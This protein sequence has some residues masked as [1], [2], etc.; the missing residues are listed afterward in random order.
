MEFKPYSA[1]KVC[2]FEA[3]THEYKNI[4]IDRILN[5]DVS[6]IDESSRKDLHSIVAAPFLPKGEFRMPQILANSIRHLTHLAIVLLVALVA[7][8]ASGAQSGRAFAA[9]DDVRAYVIFGSGSGTFASGTPVPVTASALPAGYKFSRWIVSGGTAADPAASSTTITPAANARSVVA[10]A[11]RE[12]VKQAAGG[13]Q[14]TVYSGTGS[15]LYDA[16]A[17][18]TIAANAAPAGYQ[19]SYWLDPYKLVV[20]AKA[21]NTTLTMPATRAYVYAIFARSTTAP[22]TV[23][24]TVTGGTPAGTTQ[25]TPGAKLTVKANAPAAGQVFDKWTGATTGLANAALAETILTVPTTPVALTATFKPAAAGTVAVTVTGGTPAGVTQQKPG[26]KITVKANAPAA[27][28]VFDKWT[29]TTTALA[30]AAAAETILT[31]PATAASITATYKLASAGTVAVNVFGGTPAGTTQQTPGT[32]LTITAGAPAAGK[33]FDKWAGL[34]AGLADVTAAQ[35]VLTVPATPV[36]VI[37]MYKVASTATVPLTVTG[38]TPAGTT[39]Q[40]PGAKI[41]VKANAPVAGKVFDKWTGATTGL[42]NA[43]A[44]ET[45]LTMPAT[46]VAIAATYKDAPVTAVALTVTGGTPAGTTQQLP[47]AKITVKANAPAAGQVFDKWT[48]TTAGLA[49]AAAAETILTMPSTAVAIA[50]TYKTASAGTATVTVTGGTPASSSVAQGKTLTITA[51]AAPAGKVFDQWTGDVATLANKLSA[52]T[53]LTVPAAATAVSVAASYKTAPPVMVNV[54]VTNGTKSGSYAVGSKITI[55]A[56]APPAGQAFD[57]WTGPATVVFDNATLAETM[58]TVPATATAVN[59]TFKAVAP[60]TV[61]TLSSP[62]NGG[63]VSVMG[64]TVFGT[65]KAPSTADTLM[66][67][68][69]TSGRKVPLD[70]DPTTGKFALRLFEGDAPV[71]AK[72]TLTF[73]RKDKSGTLETGAVTL[74]GTSKPADL[75]QIVG[76]LTFGATPALINQI[77]T[78]GFNTWVTQQLNPASISDASLTAMKPESLLRTATTDESYQL[79]ESI[80]WW[81]T[82]YAAYS[83][84]QLLEVMTNFWNNHFWSVDKGYDVDMS[85]IDELKGFRTNALGKF[86]E[87]LR[88]SSKS[89]QM[90]RYLDNVDSRKGAINENYAR[91]VLELHTV[92]VNGGYGNAD[93]IAVAR[94]LTGWSNQ[95]TTADGVKPRLYDFKFNSNNH[96]TADKLIPFLTGLKLRDGSTF[97]GVIKAQAGAAGEQEGE[98]MLDI[99]ARHPK[100]QEFVCG[101]LVQL[102]VSD[103]RPANFVSLCMAEWERTD[104]NMKDILSKIL[105]D[106]TYLTTADYQRSKAKT[107]YEAIVSFLRNYGIYP[108]QAKE[109]DFYNNLRYIVNDAG[110]DMVSFGVPTGFKE[111]G[112]AW[113]NTASFIQKFRGLTSQV[114]YYTNAGAGGNRQGTVSYSQ[115]IKDAGM[116]TAQSAAAYL[117]ALTAGDRYRQDEYDAV[118]AALKGTQ[119]FAPLTRDEEPALRRAVGLIITLP[120]VQ[121]Q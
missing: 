100:T 90:M 113:T 19:F 48:G 93:I 3:I 71:G 60:T 79:R 66:A 46:A 41:T 39:Q 34:T 56:N 24:V 33:A 26:T 112:K 61:V 53:V 18:V 42:A 5:W 84:R 22:G 92:G 64:E 31:V 10:Y 88:V 76:R 6:W 107:P 114:T 8:F 9:A 80:N 49:N 30:N 36:T 14:L 35:T 86:R 78:T 28:Q 72:V 1:R 111:V 57:K 40:A 45:I 115:L 81:Q 87:L 55:T 29:G 44:A 43:A 74:T 54:T 65:V 77:K 94:V 17:S 99:L 27:G 91:E 47:G 37:A 119:G 52:T 62:I 75:Q 120:S 117:L 101:K 73:E 106:P 20:D 109:R 58:M 32:K 102:L 108:V 21:A 12:V 4:K 51:G 121:L 59:A 15:G 110:M 70:L 95:Q 82:S 89:P 69:S 83:Q 11:V 116:T 98:Q 103:D 16:G 63:Q 25:Q 13:N 118:V 67:T 97:D 85:D 50:A 105:L 23:A 2:E 96:D 68:V 104:G 7:S 38:G